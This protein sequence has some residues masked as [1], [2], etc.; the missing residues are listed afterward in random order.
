MSALLVFLVSLAITAGLVILIILLLA[1][2]GAYFMTVAL[3]TTAFIN[4][5]ESLKAIVP[6][7]IGFRMSEERD[8]DGQQWL[9]Q[10]AVGHEADGLFGDSLPGTMRFQR[11]LWRKFNVK[12]IS[13]VWPFANRHN[14]DILSRERILEGAR[15]TP[16]TPLKD[17]VV[18]SPNPTVVDSL[19]F[20]V[21][22][23]VY[24]DG[25][26]L[27]GDNARIN[28]LLLPIYRQVIP[29]LP[30]YY[31]KGDFFTQLD[32]ALETALVDF[33]ARHRVAVHKGTG[34]DDP[35]K[36][37][38][39]MNTYEPPEDAGR[40]AEYEALYEPSPLT[41]SLWLTLA[42]GGG[43]SP[44]EK[45][46]HSLNVSKTYRDSLPTRG[47]PPVPGELMAY[48]DALTHGELVLDI[49]GP[50]AT[51]I[52]SGII[53]RFGFAMVSFRVVDWEPHPDT[54]ALAKALLAK[55]TQFHT[56][57]GV[58]QEAYGIRDATLAKAQGES[59]RYERLVTALISHGVDATI[60]AQVVGTQIRMEN[61]RDSKLTTYVEGGASASV[62]VPTSPS[63]S[64]TP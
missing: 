38:F 61:V 50:F 47:T 7:V 9:I 52:P 40:K 56:A 36:G 60:A 33:F 20:L 31:L 55:E 27:A 23:P 10:T 44:L 24:V 29:V 30:V 32:A 6:N 41:Y 62:M 53:P 57:E 39:A 37:Q 22:R 42:K 8:P 1:N 3:G 26:Q 64:S 45:H 59:N 18:A 35:K 12:F 2:L 48:I 58:R 49:T 19:L 28:L 51:I 54:V 63:G 13:F 11:W 34:A 5:G 17:R 14:F 43:D 21:P 15:V 46:L 16:N 4:M 25:I